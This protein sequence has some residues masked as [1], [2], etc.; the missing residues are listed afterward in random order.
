[1]E[2]SGKRFDEEVLTF[3]DPDGPKL[4]M[5]GYARAKELLVPRGAM[6]PPGHA[7]RGFDA[8]TLSEQGFEK[9]QKC[10]Q[11]NAPLSAYCTSYRG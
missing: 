8:V 5:V 2:R 6:V 1:M 9:K 4:E 10:C 3:A 7:I 11:I